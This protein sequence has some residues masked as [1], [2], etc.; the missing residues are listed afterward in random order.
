MAKVKITLIRSVNL[1]NKLVKA[2]SIVEVEEKTA[3]SLKAI[4]AAEDVNP[5]IIEAEVLGGDTD[6]LA[7]LKEALKEEQ[8]EALKAA[9]FVDLDS[10]QDV[11]KAEL[12]AVDTIGD[13]TADKI[14]AILKG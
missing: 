14:L 1:D 9:G 10:F 5:D 8:V 7:Q 6:K 2:G 11:K 12:V 13:A 3:A 4:K